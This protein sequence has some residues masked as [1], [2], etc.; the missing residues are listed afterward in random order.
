[1]VEGEDEGEAG[2]A[3]GPGWLYPLKATLTR[4]RS[5]A[6]LLRSRG[7][8]GGAGVRILFYHRVAADRDV[9]AVRPER[10]AAQMD[11]LA[12]AG[13]RGVDVTELGRRLA[14]GDA[15]PSLVGLSFDDGYLDVAEH[16]TPVLEQHGFTASVFIS[17]AVTSGDGRFTWYAQQPPLIPWELM[18]ELDG[19]ASLRFEAHTRTH[20]NLTRLAED[21]AR[22]EIV[23]GKAELEEQLGRTVASFCYPAGLYGPRERALVEAAGFETA[24]S[25]E[26]GVNDARTDRF[27][28]HRIQVDAAD[29]L[30]DFRAK[31]FGGFDAPLA[32]REAW[33]R[34]RYGTGKPRDDSAAR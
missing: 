12:S 1:V 13:L 10:F 19:R 5:L 26:P 21:D 24:V 7:R 8:A 32:G 17:T 22:D 6:W 23:R 27:A 34:L 3:L 2:L 20:P 9:L 29:S 30:L 4:G 28:L 11:L 33:R 25:C 18:R 16:A 14:A 15:D 31:A